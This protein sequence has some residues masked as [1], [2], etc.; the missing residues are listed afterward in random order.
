M[1]K[2]NNFSMGKIISSKAS[3]ITLL[4]FTMMLTFILITED[5]EKHSHKIGVQT[6]LRTSASKYMVKS[7]AKLPMQFEENEG[8]VEDEN[9]KF[10]S[11]SKGYTL[12]L[13]SNK[14]IFSIPNFREGRNSIR[15]KT[16]LK[17]EAKGELQRLEINLVGSNLSPQ[18][19]GVDELPGKSN[20]F[21]GNNQENWITD[22]KNY[23]KVQYSKV[24][25]GIDLI[26]YGNHE[27][28]EY[29][30]IVSPG[31]NPDAIVM[32]I[33]D[34]NDKT[35]DENCNLILTMGESKIIMKVP[36]AYQEKAGNREMIS[37][38]YALNSENQ[39]AFNVGNYDPAFPL[40]IDPIVVFSTYLNENTDPGYD[41]AIDT[42][43]NIYLT[44]ETVY[45]PATDSAAQKNP[46]GGFDVFIAKMNPD[47]SSYVYVTYLGGEYDDRGFGIDVDIDGYA[48]VT[49]ETQSENFPTYNAVQPNY[50][51]GEPFVY[52]DAFVAKLNPNGSA[53][54]Y[55]TYLGGDGEDIGHGIAVDKFGNAN[56]VG[57]TYT[58]DFPVKNALQSNYADYGDAFVTKIKADGSD[59][60][61]S[62][63]LG[64]YGDDEGFGIAVDDDGNTYVTGMAGSKDFPE[65][66]PVQGT[67]GGDLFITKINPLGTS[68]I[69]SSSIGGE[70]DP[71][72]SSVG[73]GKAIAVDALGQAYIAGETA[74]HNFPTLSAVQPNFGGG[75]QDGIVFK[76]SYDGSLLLFSTYL[77]GDQI[78]NVH[79]IAIDPEGNVY[80]TGETQSSNFPTDSATQST[81]NGYLDAFITQ[82]TSDGLER[83]FSTYLG[84][85]N[86]DQGYGI[87]ADKN[88]YVY[89]TGKTSSNDFPTEQAMYPTGL[90]GGYVVKLLMVKKELTVYP[91]PIV[92]PQTLPGETQTET[93]QLINSGSGPLQLINIDVE[94]T[95]L[96]TLNNVPSLPLTL[97]GGYM[98]EIDITYSPISA[99]TAVQANY[100]RTAGAGT[101]VVLTDAE[102]PITSVPINTTGI[103][104]NEIGDQSDAD[105]ADGKCDIDPDKPG[106][107]CTLRAAIEH[108]NAWKDVTNIMFSIPSEGVPV[109]KPGRA[110]PTIIYPVELDGSTQD[111]GYVVL[112]GSNAGQNVNGLTISAGNSTLKSMNIISFGENG[113]YLTENGGN[114]IDN[115][116]I[117]GNG[118]SGILIVKTSNDTIKN[119][120]ISGNNGDGINIEESSGNVIE[121]CKIGTDY[122]GKLINRNLLTGVRIFLGSN[123][124]L[125]DNVISGNFIGVHIL[126]TKT[127]EFAKSNILKYN[128]IGTT[129]DG[130]DVIPNKNSGIL[131]VDAIDTQIENNIISGNGVISTPLG[132]GIEHGSSS[133][134]TTIKNNLIGT[135]SLGK[136]AI[137]N[138][139]GI[140][141]LSDSVNILSN[142]ISG[143]ASNG[144]T[145]G[146]LSHVRGNLI[147]ANK[148]GTDI[149]GE[150]ELS[151]W[152]HGIE[153]KNGSD[154][155]LAENIISSNGK[156]GIF[157][158]QNSRGIRIYK[159]NI[160]TDSTG[161]NPL[162]NYEDG[163]TIMKSSLNE[164]WENLISANEK[165]GIFA[166]GPKTEK[167]GLLGIKIST[168][169]IGTD[170]NK[171]NPNNNMGN[172]NQGI[173]IENTL[174]NIRENDIGFNQIG[175]RYAGFGI[176]IK[177]EQISY[178]KIY[179]NEVGLRILNSYPKVTGNDIYYNSI[180]VE[181]EEEDVET[182]KIKWISNN[183][184]DN[185]G[186]SSGIH[187][188][189]AWINIED[190]SISHDAGNAITVETASKV[191]VNNNNIFSNQGYGL[192]NLVPLS[193]IDGQANWWG[194][195]SGPGGS[196]PGSGDAVT[197]GVN[198]SN[199]LTEMVSLVTS[200]ELDTVTM[201]SG[202]TDTAAVHLQ[203]WESM[204][205]VVDVQVTDG[206]G[207]LQSPASFSVSLDGTMGAAV[208]LAF[209]IPQSTP[210]GTEN[211]V[212]VISTSQANTTDIDTASFVIIAEQAEVVAISVYPDSVAIAPGDSISFTAIG[213][214]QF[215]RTVEFIPQWVCTGGVIDSA[216]FYYAGSETGIFQVTATDVVSGL[217]AI[218]IVNIAYS[219]SVDDN[220]TELP[221]SFQLFQNYPN[222]FNPSTKIRYSI[223]S[224]SHI[225][226]EVFDILGKKMA[227]LVNEEKLAG[228]YEVELNGN[229]LASG[230]YFCRLQAGEYVS[231]KKLLLLK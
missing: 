132:A 13:T 205:D 5:E 92:F 42:I 221:T 123:N 80:V 49:G 117:E 114:I 27:K 100:K 97:N 93:V 58:Y 208:Q 98:V 66:T 29:D 188:K 30:F 195:A 105:I 162:G 94:P 113:I 103:I 185:S 56:V 83:P 201:P 146:D 91:N 161:M 125:Q 111:G 4:F 167:E 17:S 109:I 120:A 191:S 170:K 70:Y 8:Q 96:F 190:N 57:L 36:V 116:V 41:L 225:N 6:K 172:E 228:V 140:N 211:H 122:L 115:C 40:I 61:Y 95:P 227:T 179:N 50:G 63:Y 20:Y 127:L 147:Q 126:G 135:N 229:N 206:Q 35:F 81:L 133:K 169:K 194:D 174:G 87:A 198:F 136:A 216:G 3:L 157:V 76:L 110:L 32:Q 86:W 124:K 143:N 153:F 209:A 164:I 189:N 60:I 75:L 45:F 156:S 15:E 23:S 43:G 165:S 102:E 186:P 148:I 180:G 212:Q 173:D 62:T 2:I 158:N 130:N 18:M 177:G 200:A 193:P 44:G 128:K 101:L 138:G 52:G 118:Q 222:P 210:N 215:Y 1:Y 163:I 74:Q 33:D 152:G 197:S 53:F 171:K 202:E 121:N 142:T 19:M 37:V 160:G 119:C 7:F 28:L 217:T 31:A 99:S 175:L 145:I 112:D 155:V 21:L 22:V 226:L 141:V 84:G 73:L 150:R 55:S 104:V 203:N 88:G 78:E 159:N 59:F 48:Y 204:L 129:A 65:I 192:N 219:V 10:I 218:A 144:I 34:C 46:G 184:H 166:L 68:L 224:A 213:F 137:A 176:Y 149:S 54:V 82:L 67:P 77:G 11:R 183:V 181:I 230:V 26:F 231:T 154:N 199:W 151:N 14:T 64:G 182:G 51:G 25:N 131:L 108:V 107:Q 69:Y 9:V 12:V 196:G 24:Y 79:D 89:V 168:N 47:G 187:I 139:V 16:G 178:N 220:F 134:R 223:P 85:S 214:D 72:Y 38:D 39:V 106:N 71:N 207:W 90:G